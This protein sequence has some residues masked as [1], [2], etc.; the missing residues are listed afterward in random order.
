LP[1]SSDYH[2]RQATTLVQLARETNN[3]DTATALLKLAAEYLDLAEE[4]AR[5]S[6][7]AAATDENA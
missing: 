4:A 5:P 3:A 1:I 6:Q 7:V 2:R